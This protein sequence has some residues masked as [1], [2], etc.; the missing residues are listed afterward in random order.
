MKTVLHQRQIKT[1]ALRQCEPPHV[2]IWNKVIRD[3]NRDYCINPD[4]DVRLI[5][6]KI[7]WI[8]YVVVVSHFAKYGTNR[9]LIV[10]GIMLTNFKKIHDSTIVKKMTK[11]SGIHTQIR[12]I[13]KS[14]SLLESHPL[15]MPVK[16]GRRSFL[17]LSVIVFTKWQ[18]ERSHN[19]HL[20]GGGNNNN[21]II[22][23]MFFSFVMN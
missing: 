7:L 15:P 22:I 1:R 2:N 23:I 10:W 18:T 12:I 16:F 20:V 5:F 21:I 8:H 3:S 19:V 14:S 6:P 13:T 11:W 9:L 17:R 4:L